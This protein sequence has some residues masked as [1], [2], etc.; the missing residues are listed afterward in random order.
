MFVADR[1]L[2]TDLHASAT[3]DNDINALKNMGSI[4]RVVPL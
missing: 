1:L 3:A 2:D 4:P